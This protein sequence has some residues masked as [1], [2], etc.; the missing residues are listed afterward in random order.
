MERRTLIKI[1][2]VAVLSL[3]LLVWGLSFLKGENLFSTEHEY[4]A[5]YD[6]IDGLQESNPVTLSGFKIGK[7]TSIAFAGDNKMSIAVR[8]RIINDFDIPKGTTARIVNMDIMGTKGIEFICPKKQEGFHENGDTLKSSR[9]GSIL[10]QMLELVLPMKDDLVGFLSASDSVMHSLNM[11]L[12]E[13]NR[14]NIGAS[15]SNLRVLT[16]HLSQNS[17]RIDSVMRNLTKVSQSIGQNTGNIN[18]ALHN[19]ASFSDTL[20]HLSVNQAITKAQQTL[21]QLNTLLNN[22]NNGDGSI[23]KIIRSDS[24]YNSLERASAQL[25]II[26]NEFEKNPK[27]YINLSVFGGKDKS[28]KKNKKNQTEQ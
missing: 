17:N 6:K 22:I 16:A 3:A 26:L 9:E 8:M 25:D 2:I 10:D 4:I 12:N 28:Q 23:S 13:N 11:L 20:S 18:R 1:G 24:I 7:V 21:E 5:I 14:E 27:K 15:L 19:F